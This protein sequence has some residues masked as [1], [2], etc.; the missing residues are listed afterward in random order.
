MCG[1][2]K[3]AVHGGLKVVI[4]G[5]GVVTSKLRHFVSKL[6]DHAGSSFSLIFY[7]MNW[8]AMSSPSYTSMEY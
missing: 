3:P 6:P 1:K 8:L 2:L 5:Q 4:D 7:A